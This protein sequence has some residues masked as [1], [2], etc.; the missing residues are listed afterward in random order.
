LYRQKACGRSIAYLCSDNASA[1]TQKEEK[2]PEAAHATTATG[3]ESGDRIE[4][5]AGIQNGDVV[6]ISGRIY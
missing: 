5:K 3:S 2:A 4:I 6:V 1:T